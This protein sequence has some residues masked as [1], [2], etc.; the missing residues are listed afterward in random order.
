MAV[1]SARTLQERLLRWV[2]VTN[3]GDFGGADARPAGFSNRLGVMRN[4][5]PSGRNELANMA[6][7]P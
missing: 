4:S 7:T 3:A 1:P 2:R 5:R 6:V